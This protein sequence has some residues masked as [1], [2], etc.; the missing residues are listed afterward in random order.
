M[1]PMLDSGARWGIASFI[2]V[3]MVKRGS[4][5][6]VVSFGRETFQEN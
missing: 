6:A 2:G 4:T 1:D 5:F 3:Q